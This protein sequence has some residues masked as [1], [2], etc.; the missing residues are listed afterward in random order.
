[1]RPCAPGVEVLSG[2]CYEKVTATRRFLPGRHAAFTLIEIMV[3]VGIM[4]IVMAMSVPLVYK[5]RNR[6]AIN[7][8][9]RDVMEV[10][11]QARAQAILQGKITELLFYPKEKRCQVGGYAG[12]KAPP[13]DESGE[14]GMPPPPPDNSGLGATINDKITIEMLDVNLTEYKGLDFAR[15]RFFPNGTC[16]EFTLVLH[17]DKG[18]WYKIWLEITTGLANVG[19]V[20]E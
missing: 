17:S 11:S 4:A 13:P 6:E 18:E 2:Y 5:V 20:N 7:K 3:V 8:A 19:P 9:V 14:V 10:C 16:D 15:V 12:Q 1:M